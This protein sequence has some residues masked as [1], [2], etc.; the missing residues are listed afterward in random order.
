MEASQDVKEVFAHRA[1]LAS[2]SPYLFDLFTAET[3]SN[4]NQYKLT[5]NFDYDA[6][7]SLVEYAYTGRLVAF[8]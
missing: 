7:E 3:K 5:G 2:A 8:Y 4:R 6:F 1:V